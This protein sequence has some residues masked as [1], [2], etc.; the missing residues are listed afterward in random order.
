MSVVVCDASP[1][2]A[3]TQISQLSLLKQLF[4]ALVVPSAVAREVAPSLERPAWINERLL[5][6]PISSQVL[7]ASL[8]PGESEAI[9]L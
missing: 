5:A 9:G 1:L 6:Q 3:L 2:I 7:R 8:G 4:S